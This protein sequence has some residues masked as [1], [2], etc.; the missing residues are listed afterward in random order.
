MEVSVIIPSFQGRNKLPVILNALERQSYR[1]FEVIIVLDGSNDQ[2]GEWLTQQKFSFASLKVIN[3]E[4]RGRAGARNAGV[5][6]AK[7]NILIFYDDDTIP[8]PDSIVSHVAFHQD[9]EHAILTGNTPQGLEIEPTDFSCY[10]AYLSNKWVGH[11]PDNPVLLEKNNVFMSAANCSLKKNTFTK[12]DGFSESLKDAEDKEFSI[13]A[14]KCGIA[15][16]F[17]KQ[18]IAV[19]NESTTC[20]SYVLRL[21]QYATANRTVSEMHPDFY[22]TELRPSSVKNILYWLAAHAS[23]VTIIDK[24]NFLIV[25]PRSIRYRIYDLIT[26]ALSMVY[27]NVRV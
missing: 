10:R 21:R 3:Q 18:N 1:D 25:L 8:A 23:L 6:H 26:Y 2:S 20:R 27:S 5:G 11:F 12:M 13:R 16:Y 22:T 14:F 15:L 17:H 9:R 4:N 19:H 24:F 7:G